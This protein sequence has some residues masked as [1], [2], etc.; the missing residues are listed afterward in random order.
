MLLVFA[1]TELVTAQS[2]LQGLIAIEVN[3]NA[4]D[5]ERNG[6]AAPAVLDVDGDG[7]RDLLVGEAFHGQLRVYGNIGTN[8]SPDFTSA[9]DQPQ[10]AK[11]M[12][13]LV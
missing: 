4:L 12:F 9:L 13:T 6:H 5:V 11:P 7:L 10:T 2:S 1:L 3:G 8:N